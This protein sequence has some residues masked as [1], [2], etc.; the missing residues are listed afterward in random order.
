MTIMTHIANLGLS[1]TLATSLKTL[2]FTNEWHTFMNPENLSALGMAMMFI[3]LLYKDRKE[4]LE[5]NKEM[6]KQLEESIKAKDVEIRRL[7][8]FIM[9]LKK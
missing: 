7:N 3:W 5:M 9:N 1:V 2:E 4:L 6:N 8:E